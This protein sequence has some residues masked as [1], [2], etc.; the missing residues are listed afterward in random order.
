MDGWTDGWMQRDGEGD[1]ISLRGNR[2]VP[3]VSFLEYGRIPADTEFDFSFFLSLMLS[4]VSKYQH[5][6]IAWPAYLASPG[7]F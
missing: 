6:G 3:V 7:F 2:F 5:F 4:F 1:V